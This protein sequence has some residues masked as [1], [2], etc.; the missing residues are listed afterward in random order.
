MLPFT[1]QDGKLHSQAGHVSQDPSACILNSIVT[2]SPSKA[3]AAEGRLQLQDLTS[4][5]TDA[6]PVDLEPSDDPD[7]SGQPRDWNSA[8]PKIFV[9]QPHPV[10]QGNSPC[11]IG[12]KQSNGSSSYKLPSNCSELKQDAP[13]QVEASSTGGR[14]QLM[15]K[16]NQVK[17]PIELNL[18][19]QTDQIRRTDSP[20][21]LSPSVFQGQSSVRSSGPQY[22]SIDR[23]PICQRSQSQCN[24]LLRKRSKAIQCTAV[25]CRPLHSD[26]IILDTFGILAL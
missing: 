10:D 5:L 17:L 26:Y 16:E 20:K 8:I 2:K 25:H 6:T 23:Q 21:L 1:L 11:K 4:Q 15:E 18:Q 22:C 7:R 3:E 19:E 9:G 24:L 12:M 13:T 14:K